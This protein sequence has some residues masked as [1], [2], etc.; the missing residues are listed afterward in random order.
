MVVVLS[1][2]KFVRRFCWLKLI[3]NVINVILRECN[4]LIK[5]YNFLGGCIG[6]DYTLMYTNET[7]FLT[8]LLLSKS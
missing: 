2:V 3:I 1:F 8:F 6:S 5:S 7:L 4:L